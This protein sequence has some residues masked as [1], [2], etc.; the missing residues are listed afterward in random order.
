MAQINKVSLRYINFFEDKNIFNN[1]NFAMIMNNKP[2]ESSVTNVTLELRAGNIIN[3]LRIGTPAK[4]QFQQVTKGGSVLD[5]ST[6]FNDKSLDFFRSMDSVLNQM[7]M[8]EKS[9]FFE[10]LSDEFLATLKPEY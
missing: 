10:L 2:V 6:F 7:H 3:T 5:I 9:L 4:I 8:A 1:L